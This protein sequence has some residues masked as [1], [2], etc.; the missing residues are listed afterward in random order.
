MS[1]RKSNIDK[2]QSHVEMKI[3]FI[4]EASNDDVQSTK[5]RVDTDSPR[6]RNKRGT[7]AGITKINKL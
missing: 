5:N 4:R 7:M 3:K 2:I 6:Q 1:K